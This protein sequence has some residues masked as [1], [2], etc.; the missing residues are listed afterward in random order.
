[1][2]QRW[3]GLRNDSGDPVAFVTKAKEAYQ[4]I[5][6]DWTKKVIVFSDGLDVDR[7]VELQKICKDAGFIRWCRSS[8][9]QENLY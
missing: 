4:S 5:G 3:R 2:A 8:A 9:V 6:I 1:M 7:C